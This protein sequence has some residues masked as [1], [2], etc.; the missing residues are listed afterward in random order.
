MYFGLAEDSTF[1]YSSIIIYGY[2][3]NLT[4][5]YHLELLFNVAGIFAS[6][7]YRV[8]YPHIDQC[9]NGTGTHRNTH[10]NAV[11]VLLRRPD[12]W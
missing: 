4:L 2:S 8:I 7:V 6:T 11:P 5:T 3:L 9:S 1:N 10:R 12:S